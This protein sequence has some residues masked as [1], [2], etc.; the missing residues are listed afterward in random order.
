[1]AISDL[2]KSVQVYCEV[3]AAQSTKRLYSSAYKQFDSFCSELQIHNPFPVTESPLCYFAAH[4]A[5]RGS[6]PS[7]IKLYRHMFKS[8]LVIQSQELTPRWPTSSWFFS[9]IARKMRDDVN[10]AS[11][12]PR[13]PITASVLQ[14]MAAVLACHPPSHDNAMVWYGMICIGERG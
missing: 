9:G 7:S 5:Q 6:A 3:G 2:E 1:M 12:K 10:V 8:W 4:L 14:Q 13:L 11:P